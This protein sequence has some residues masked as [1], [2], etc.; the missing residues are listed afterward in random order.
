[1]EI[2]E[3]DID[4]SNKNVHYLLMKNEKSR[5]NVI[6]VDTDGPDE[7]KRIRAFEKISEWG[8]DIY[9]P[10]FPGKGKSAPNDIYDPFSDY[11]KGSQF[12]YDFIKKLNLKN[13]F[14]IGYSLGGEIAL[15]SAIDH[16]EKVGNIVI[17][18]VPGL[19]ELK[20]E[21]SRINKPTMI[22]WGKKDDVVNPAAGESFHDLIAGSVLKMMDGGHPIQ[23]QKSDIFFSYLK[24]FFLDH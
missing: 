12:I 24:P 2:T 17:I 1:M 3:S 9:Y 21:L 16:P 8:F 7:W 15:K 20:Y 10:W 22:L 6:L 13:A 23:F 14:L 4:L 18:G 11:T 5:G 19:N